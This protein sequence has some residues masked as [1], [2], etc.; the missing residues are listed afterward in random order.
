MLVPIRTY[1]ISHW[2]QSSASC[3]AES[4]IDR[5]PDD[6]TAAP[7]E[8]QGDN[9]RPYLHHS[10]SAGLLLGNDMLIFEFWTDSQHLDLKA[11]DRLSVTVH[12]FIIQ[13]TVRKNFTALA[14]FHRCWMAAVES[15]AAELCSLPPCPTVPPLSFVFCFIGILLGWLFW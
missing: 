12:R 4:C 11:A 5:G 14:F 8:L 15:C 3:K 2:I 1:R 13:Y 6:A 7:H 9:L 10:G